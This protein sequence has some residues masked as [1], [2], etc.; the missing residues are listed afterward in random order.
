[1]FNFFIDILIRTL[2]LQAAMVEKDAA[3]ETRIQ[4]YCQALQNSETVQKAQKDLIAI[5]A[6]ALLKLLQGFQGPIQ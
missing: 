3:L 6:E 4:W 5:D 1:M 2:A